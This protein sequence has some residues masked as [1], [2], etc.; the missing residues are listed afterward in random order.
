MTHH[1]DFKQLVRARMRA[2]GQPYTAARADLLR[3]NDA[4][5]PPPSPAPPVPGAASEQWQRAEAEHSR[6]LDRFLRDGRVVSVPAR[7]KARVHVL[8]HLLSLFPAGRTYTEPEVN[9]ILRPV[10]ED[11]AFWRR[12]LVEY[13]YLQRD[14]GRYWLPDEVPERTANLRQEAPAWEALW[15]PTHLRD[16]RT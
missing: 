5:A 8:L 14:A 2:T 6:A 1:S 10:V 11:W 15:L 3:E 12:E 13:G 4:A 7:R 9:D 16:R